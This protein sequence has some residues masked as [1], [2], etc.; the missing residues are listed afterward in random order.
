LEKRG[1]DMRALL[2]LIGL[3]VA[4]APAYAAPPTFT[5][6]VAPILFKSCVECHRPT[7][8]AP[9]SLMTFDDARPWAR[10]V[11]Q[12]V[13]AREMPPWGADP[14]V[15][16]GVHRGGPDHSSGPLAQ[17]ASAHSPLL[18]QRHDPA[19]LEVSD[20]VVASGLHTGLVEIMKSCRD[21]SLWT[22]ARSTW[23]GLQMN[24]PP[25]RCAL[26][27]VALE[28]SSVQTTGERLPIASRN[29]SGSSLGETEMTHESSS[30]QPS[31]AMHFVQESFTATGGTIRQATTE[32]SKPNSLCG[33][34]S[35]RFSRT[36]S[37]FAPSLVGLAR[38]FWKILYS[39][40]ARQNKRLQPTPAG[41]IMRPPRLKRGR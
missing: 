1:T 26:F 16:L 33:N 15:D 18:C 37:L 32:C 40:V 2:V 34:R 20:I 29:A 11:K 25:V 31:V 12:K 19:H 6:D 22:V 4:A 24:I 27:W 30:Q 13:V 7:G 35:Q 23:A 14:T 28:G 10:A 9:M 41:A 17:R 39:R 3:T 38:P 21:S 5:K 36:P 8:M